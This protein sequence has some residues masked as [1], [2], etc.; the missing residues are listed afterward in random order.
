MTETEAFEYPRRLRQLTEVGRQLTRAAEVDE[1][2]RVVVEAA[3]GLVPA[4]AALIM[5]EHGGRGFVVRE[6]RGVAQEALSADAG[7]EQDSIEGR[8]RSLFG[9]ERLE[10]VLAVPLVARGDVFGLLAVGQTHL[11]YEARSE[12][13]LSALADQAAVAIDSTRMLA[14]RR[15]DRERVR[16]M[17]AVAR[18]SESALAT[19]SHDVRTPVQ[20]LKWCVE[21]LESE[22][23]GPLT[24]EQHAVVERISTSAEHLRELIEHVPDIR[25]ASIGPEAL[26]LDDHSVAAVVDEALSIIEPKAKR[27][28]H[29]ISCEIDA[30]LVAHCDR[31]RLRQA[32]VNLLDNAVKY[33]PTGGAI[34]VEGRRHDDG[35][36]V[37]VFVQDTGP[38]VPANKAAKLFDPYYRA[39]RREADSSLGLGLAIC[40]QALRAMG[41]EVALDSSGGPGAIFVVTVPAAS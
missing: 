22:S 35:E 3:R 4:E 38:G 19:V 33:T 6:A 21:L 23:L 9:A 28:A 31:G 29:R 37:Q 18:R 12:W 1:V 5:L 20:A 2:L 26:E 41:G 16:T 32:L 34:V 24:A 7:A 8:L 13:L 36:R 15:R 40:R 10:D 25:S 17:E 11:Q 14:E 39:T 30:R 27:K